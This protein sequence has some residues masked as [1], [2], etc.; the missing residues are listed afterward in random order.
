MNIQDPE[1]RLKKF[2]GE[3]DKKHVKHITD[4]VI[5]KKVL[6]MGCGYGTTTARLTEMGYDC[7]GIDYS[8]EAVAAAKKRFPNCKFEEANA[9]ALPY[10]NAAFDTIIL[11]DALHHFYGEANF[12]K[13]K[14]EILRVARPHSRIIFFDPNVNF[15]L[16]TMRKL[17]NH[18]DEECDYETAKDIMDKWGFKIIHKSFNT[19][20]SLPLSG[21]YVGYNFVPDAK[22]IWKFTL[23]LEKIFEK[24]IRGIGLG[25][26]LCWR[27]IIV[28]ER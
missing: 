2:W 24:L 5:G 25:R 18:I 6:D 11:R 28:G 27:Y 23:G 12:E 10:E 19:V 13:V 3:V 1:K 14:S 16:K 9:E 17:S 20:F 15:M 7:I 21:G 22:P 26:Q 8:P 4:F